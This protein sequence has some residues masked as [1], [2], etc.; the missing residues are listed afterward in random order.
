MIPICAS[1]EAMPRGIGFVGKSGIPAELILTSQTGY[2][3]RRSIFTVF[4]F[5]V[6]NMLKAH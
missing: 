1:F 2:E 4:H 3:K 5:H 6:M